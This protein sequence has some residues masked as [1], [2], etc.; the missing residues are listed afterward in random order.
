MSRP[1][2]RRTAAGFGTFALIGSIMVAVPAI[3]IATENEDGT[4][5]IDL[6]AITDLHG[7]IENAPLVQTALNEMRAENPDGTLF[8]SA[9]DNI[10][11]SAFVSAIADDEPTLEILDAMGLDY[12]AVGNHEFDRGVEDLTGRVMDLI[13][14]PYLGANVDGDPAAPINTPAYLVQEVEGVEVAII[15]TVTDETPTIVSAGGVVGLT[16]VNEVERA[17]EVAAQATA[18]GADVVVALVHADANGVASGL[19]EDVDAAFTGH[20][21]LDQVVETPSGAPVVQPDHYGTVLGHIQLTVDPE[22]GEITTGVAENIAMFGPEDEQGN[23]PE[24]FERDADIEAMYQTALAESEVLGNEPVGTVSG[25]IDRAARDGAGNGS[26]RGSESTFG[27]M[28]GDV[29]LFASDQLDLGADIGVINPGGIRADLDPNGDGTVTFAEAFTAQPFGNT[30]GVVTISGADLRLLLEQQWREPT[31]EHPYLALGWSENF[32]Y[33]FDP[34]APQGE[35]IISLSIDGVPVTDD[36]DVTIAG[37]TFLLAG[38]DSFFAF[39][40]EVVDETCINTVTETGKPDVESLNEYLQANEGLAPNYA[41]RSIGWTG[42]LEAAAGETVEVTISG[43]SMSG[44]NDE[45]A[46][47]VSVLLG[48]TLVGSSTDI[49]N[50]RSNGYNDTGVATVEVTFP[51]DAAP[52]EQSLTVVAGP[53]EQ[54]VPFT[55][56]E[57]TPEPPAPKPGTAYFLND[58]WGPVANVSFAFGRTADE[59]LVGDWDGDGSDTL[60]VRRGNAF[61]LSNEGTG[62]DAE[63][64]LRYGRASDEVLVGD[65][66]GDGSDSFAVRRGNAFF[67]TNGFAGGNADETFRFGRASDEVL[68]GD[69]DATG[70]D[71]FGVRRGNAFFLSGELGGRAEVEFRYGR[72]SDEV[73]SGDW[74]GNGTDTFAVRRGNLYLISNAAVPRFA[75]QELRYGRSGDEV[76]VGDWNGDGSDTLGV[77]R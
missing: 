30:I 53:T 63:I 42:A 76:L 57:G 5:T 67:V 48:D 73:L 77:R 33:V 46:T 62:G 45:G 75:D 38:G 40:D 7:H 35:Q 60:G 74:D 72:A 36:Q 10:G 32:D 29:A 17:N 2:T 11:G 24:L 41:Q 43:L 1:S 52:G 26:N 70:A 55:V 51:E 16:F 25:P 59:V 56:G 19:S 68:V 9:G 58:G 28:L 18:D 20:S 49:D 22:S 39:C 13:D 8:L 37:N 14:F 64:E 6:A 12:S 23:Q 71:V 4:V 44:V 15:G 47:E 3:A 69:W 34:E 50:T 54:T 61:Y 31:A 21:H 27:N 65:W 66:D